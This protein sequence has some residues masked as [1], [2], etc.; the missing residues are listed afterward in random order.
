MV[1]LFL[2]FGA[3]HSKGA[4]PAAATNN[5]MEF[6]I[7]LLSLGADLEGRDRYGWA[8]LQEAARFGHNALREAIVGM[9]LDIVHL[10]LS[11]GAGPTYVY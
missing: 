5:N 10:L 8:A 7:K 6:V 1:E 9:K 3:T 2:H 11:Y 4:L